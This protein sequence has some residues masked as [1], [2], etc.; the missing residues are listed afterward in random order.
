MAFNDIEP[1]LVPKIPYGSR[2]PYQEVK[3]HLISPYSCRISA[4]SRS[5]DD[6]RIS[7]RGDTPLVDSTGP[8]WVSHRPRVQLSESTRADTKDFTSDFN[9]EFG[10]ISD[11]E[12][13]DKLW[14]YLQDELDN[15][16]NLYIYFTAGA[17]CGELIAAQYILLSIIIAEVGRYLT[18][19]SFSS[20]MLLH[21]YQLQPTFIRESYH[22]SL[23]NKWIEF[24]ATHWN[25]GYFIS[26]FKLD[27]YLGLYERIVNKLY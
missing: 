1:I 6:N 27:V 2:E 23:D 13:E 18:N 12:L 9:S 15:I 11:N 7:Q 16:K 21:I 22:G 24:A 19:Y 5:V 17:G 8:D 10:E 25:E 26:P 20:D 3:A 4:A 14:E